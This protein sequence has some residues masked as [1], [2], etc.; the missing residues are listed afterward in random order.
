MT[1]PRRI[2]AAI[3]QRSDGRILLLHRSP[4]HN[5]NPGK[6]CFVTGYVE[7]NETPADAAVREA[8]EEVGL[9]VTPTRAGEIVVVHT[10]WGATL[11]V[12]PFLCPVGDV[13]DV[14]L[15]WEHTAYVWILPEE[16]YEYDFVQQLDDDLRSLGLL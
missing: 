3:L 9:A 7:S 6:W 11:H 8:R 1:E 15:Q 13:E 12:S 10:D 16:L 5:T 14:T 4:T 2:A